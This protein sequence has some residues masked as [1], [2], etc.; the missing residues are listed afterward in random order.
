MRLPPTLDTAF[1]TRPHLEFTFGQ[2]RED[3][4]QLTNL[5]E[6]LG[7][8]VALDRDGSNTRLTAMGETYDD[9]GFLPRLGDLGT[10]FTRSPETYDDDG[11]LPGLGDVSTMNSRGPETYDEDMAW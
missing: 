7:S 4:M 3:R 9:D 5:L 2:Q 1:R 8:P 6:L 11:F 10:S